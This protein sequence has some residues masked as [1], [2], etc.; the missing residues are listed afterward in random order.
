MQY[1]N[2][3][4]DI[5]K[6]VSGTELECRV[7]YKGDYLISIFEGAALCRRGI[8]IRQS[9]QSMLLIEL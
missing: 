8:E 7:C 6:C 5:H 4:F 9:L 2:V 3:L 1:F